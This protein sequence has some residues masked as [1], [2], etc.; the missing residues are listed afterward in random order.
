MDQDSSDLFSAGY[1]LGTCTGG[2]AV[3]GCDG[4]YPG[5]PPE[6]GEP[7]CGLIGFVVLPGISLPGETFCAGGA[8]VGAE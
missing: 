5:A 7:G 2:G 8:D 1:G 3:L 6:A 4:G